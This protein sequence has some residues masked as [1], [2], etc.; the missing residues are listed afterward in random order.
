MPSSL[1]ALNP[2]GR[3]KLAALAAHTKLARPTKLDGP[4]KLADPTKLA[5]AREPHVL[6]DAARHPI[7]TPAHAGK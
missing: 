1:A 4:T 5:W 7:V 3:A 2:V 6:L